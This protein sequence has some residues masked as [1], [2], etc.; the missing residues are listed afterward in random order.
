MKNE[1]E[2]KEYYQRT[3]NEIHASEELLGKVKTMKKEEIKKKVIKMRY[4]VAAAAA[5]LLLSS[6]LVAY[7]ATG[8]TWIHAL[9]TINGE[10]K[11]VDLEEKTDEDGNKYF[12]GKIED[13]DASAVV[14]Y[15]G[16]EA[17]IPE[18]M[19]FDS[20]EVIEKD[21]KVYFVVNTDISIDITED[22]KDQKC[23][24]TFEQEGKT[25]KYEITGTVESHSVNISEAE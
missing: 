2:N 10:Q 22:I 24:G 18:N 17:D 20:P 12:E 6:N 19:Q 9:I 7:A 5:V 8:S 16:E 1:I 21:G 13:E 11:N 23:E 3:F 25:Y 4:A 14:R 15:D